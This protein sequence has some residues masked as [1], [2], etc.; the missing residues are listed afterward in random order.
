V[1]FC[2]LLSVT[3]FDVSRQ[4]ELKSSRNEVDALNRTMG[5]MR[6]DLGRAMNLLRANQDQQFKFTKKDNKVTKKTNMASI[7]H[8]SLNHSMQ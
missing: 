6:E 2:A 8:H 7:H 1:F 4:D 5:L 3:V